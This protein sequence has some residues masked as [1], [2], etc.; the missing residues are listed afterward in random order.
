MTMHTFQRMTEVQAPASELF[1]WHARE[2]AF[3]R[4][5]PPWERVQVV[6]RQGTIRDGDSIDLEIKLGPVP[7]RWRAIHRDFVDGHQFCDTQEGGPF[8]YWKHVHRLEANGEGATLHEDIS[9]RLPV[10][11]FGDW[12]AGSTVTGKLDRLFTYRHRTTRDDLA[13][14][15]RFL[16][17]KRLNV[18]MS[19]RSGL[20]GA[21]L[22]PMLTTG[23]HTVDPILRDHDG[24]QE[25]PTWRLPETNCDAVVHLAG[26]SIDGR[27]TPEKK[28]RIARSRIAGT[29]R[30]V[31][32]LLSLARKPSVFV[33][34]S[35]IGYYG[36][37]GDERLDESASQ[38]DGFLSEV[39]QEWETATRP[40]ADAGVRV[41]HARFGVVVSANGGALARMLTPFRLGGGGPIGTGNQYMSW[42][43]I[44]DAIGAIHQVLMDDGVSGPV[45]V[46]SPNPVTNRAFA[47][48]L[49]K[50]LARPAVRPLP[51]F[52]ARVAFG[53]MADAL[54]LSSARCVPD[55][56]NT[57]AYTFRYPE[58]EDALRFQLGKIPRSARAEEA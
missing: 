26:E 52:A 58:L 6:G 46:V 48:T 12:F 4:L 25:D 45:N 54:L 37:R 29:D 27:W 20:V 34:A 15:T 3:D 5:S 7:V 31:K 11:P 41:V 14:H 38:G 13:A 17:H 47:K 33:C 39:C 23:G 24:S 2:G 8:R 21:K 55:K 57:C 51:S 43:A 49:G 19:G 22:A 18:W 42:V 1:A 28:G 35:A 10:A 56:L 50:V 16:N 36:D 44:D 32:S 53:E 40:L 9:Y 30:L